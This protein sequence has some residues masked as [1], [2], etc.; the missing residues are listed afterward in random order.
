MD[1]VGYSGGKIQGNKMK[2]KKGYELAQIR[3]NRLF[4]TSSTHTH[5]RFE[6]IIN[7]PLEASEGTLKKTRVI[8]P[9]F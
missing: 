7:P 1:E 9:V 2:I 3:G 6:G 5:S 8:K 4:A